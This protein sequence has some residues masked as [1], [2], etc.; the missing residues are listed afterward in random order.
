VHTGDSIV[1]APTFTLSAKHLK[2]LRDSA[3]K[4]VRNVG[5]IG[6]CN[7]Q[8][9]LDSATGKYYV[10]EINP[11][12]SRSSAL[13]SKA[14]AYPIARVA[15]KLALGLT[16][17]EIKIAGTTADKEPIVNYVVAK[18]PRFPFDKFVQ[19]DRRLST[20]MKATGEV[21]S[22][23]ESIEEAFLKGIRSL[24]LGNC[25]LHLKKFDGLS[26]AELRDII[27]LAT[28][29][30]I[31][32]IAEALRQKVLVSKVA[33]WSGFDKFFIEKIQNIIEV[34]VSL[35]GAAGDAAIPILK[36]AKLMG[37]S[38]EYIGEV[39]GKTAIEIY[40]MRKAS[41]IYP[42]FK[43]VKEGIEYYY[44][45]YTVGVPEIPRVARNDSS[46]LQVAFSVLGMAVVGCR[47]L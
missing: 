18:F 37:F 7:V 5:I 40:E 32:A 4:I 38:D 28:D 29:E 21:M 30:R 6:G 2:V 46:W 3:V 12:L 33:E 24:E 8:Y 34:E 31:Y 35:R 14:T 19:A 1:V 42:G 22:I 45:T 16:L 41:G 15:T 23:G 44:S 11:R 9:G 25:H 39:C 10:I 47:L 26:E 17:D 36:R 43:K 27:M 13:A 20:Q